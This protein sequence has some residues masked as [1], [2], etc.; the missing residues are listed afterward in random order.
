MISYLAATPHLAQIWTMA[1]SAIFDAAWHRLEYPACAASGLAPIVHYALEGAAAGARPHLLF[2]PAWYARACGGRLRGQNP[3]VDYIRHGASA[4]IDPSPYFSAAHYRKSLESLGVKSFGRLTPLGHF[5]AYGL[6]RG[7]SPIPYFDRDWYLCNH[8]DVREAGFDPFLHF[9]ASGARDG[10]APG[11]LF[12]APWYRM[13]NADM[14]DEGHE[15]L[16]HYLSHGAAQGRRP[17]EGFDPAFYAPQAPGEALADYAGRGRAGWRSAH[18]R[19]P[20]P[21]SP[22]ALFDDFPW[23]RGERAHPHGAPFRVL[24]LASG[25]AGGAAAALCAALAPLRALDVFLVGHGLRAAG[26]AAA[27]DLDG[28]ASAGRDPGAVLDRL[29][30]ALKFCDPDAAVVDAGCAGP[31]AAQLCADLGLACLPLAAGA[32]IASFVRRLRET[33]SYREAARPT[34]SAVVPNYNHARYLDERIGSIL[35]QRARPDE[36]IFLDD[37]SSDDSL[38]V[39]RRWQDRAGLPFEIL[40]SPANGGSPFRQWARGVRAAGGDLVWIAES[41]DAAN[42]RFLERLAAQ[43]RFLDVAMAYCDSRT[44]GPAGELLATSCRFYTDTLDEEKWLAGYRAPGRRE[45]ETALAVKNVIPNVSAVLFRRE[46]IAAALPAFEEM[47]YCG[48]WAAYVEVLRAGGLAYLPEALNR[49]RQEAGG[50]TGKSERGLGAV[51][52]ALAVKRAIFAGF[53]VGAR[54][55]CL[56]LAQSVYEYERRSGEGGR[57]PFAHNPELAGPLGAMA[58]TLA[59]FGAVWP[60]Q[61]DETARFLRRLAEFDVGLDRPGRQ[62]LLA[63]VGAGLD[64]LARR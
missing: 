33:L 11:P 37:A 31:A 51:K 50:V 53:D 16:A 2:D 15:P 20:P 54:A 58:D 57:A 23:T 44:I 10:R 52:E 43:F 41:D 9:V 28:G 36:I 42:P 4:G 29:L 18:A 47:R 5:I 13:R 59:R 12:D 19:L 64:E 32:D 30:R 7:V 60:A 56:S 17:Q 61:R 26:G 27:L 22:A 39:A 45:V 34:V 40:D 38:A 49:R 35:A 63:R 8:P 48:D 1:R 21:A 55:L 24:I 14:R 6:A 25:E 3:L 62:A 46:A